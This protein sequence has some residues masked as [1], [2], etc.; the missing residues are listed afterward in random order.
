MIGN[1]KYSFDD[2]VKFKLG[3]EVMTGKIFI[4]DRFGTF[5]DSSD[6]SYD[7]LVLGKLLY[8]HVREDMIID[9]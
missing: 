9:E 2:E 3:D 1:P 8:K 5:E 7:I 4:V 6:V